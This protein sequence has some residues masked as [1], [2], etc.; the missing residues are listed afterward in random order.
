[1]SSSSNHADN[2]RDVQGADASR[3]LAAAEKKAARRMELG[4]HRWV[5]LAALVLFVIYLVTPHAGHVLGY[6]V[7][8]R[9]PES[10]DGGIKITEYLYAWFSAL[11]IGVFTTLTLLTRRAVFGLIAWMFSVVTLIFSLLAL[12]LRQTRSVAEEDMSVGVGFFLSL[13]GVVLAVYAYSR[14]ALRRSP[15]QAQLADA[16]ARD[17]N[18]DEVGYVQ[19]EAMTTRR[20]TS[21]DNNPL[22]VD[23]RRQ[24]ATERYLASRPDTDG[25]E[26]E[27]D[28]PAP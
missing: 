26:D 1:M 2:A 5:L 28:T 22:F 7:V 14:I 19:R 9:L 12:W 20:H 4:G 15:E 18:L 16:R 27:Q 17:E 24:R 11:G 23:D 25:T 10:V 3:D 8:L 13:I 21:F 6:E